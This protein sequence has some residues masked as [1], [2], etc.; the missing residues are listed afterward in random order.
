MLFGFNFLVSK[1]AIFVETNC[2]YET[3]K[4]ELIGKLDELAIASIF[5]IWKLINIKLQNLLKTQQ[6]I[7]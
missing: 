4:L 7:S 5:L 3:Q 2:F 6:N 1:R